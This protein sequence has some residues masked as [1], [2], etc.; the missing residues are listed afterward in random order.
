ML[1]RRGDVGKDIDTYLDPRDKNPGRFLSGGLYSRQLEAYLERFPAE[2][3]LILFFEDTI[4]R[5]GEQLGRVRSFLGLPA[6]STEP[7]SHK[8]VKDRKEPMVGPGLR[9]IMAPLKPL[10]R[11][12]RSTALF[13][14]ARSAFANEIA[15]PPLSAALRSRLVDF[16][17]SDAE[18]LGT[19]VRRD[20]SGWLTQTGGNTPLD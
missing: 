1:Y 4:A 10:V 14:A 2:R 9:K 6:A 11:P 12:F 8:R 13:A 17:A 3:V 7:V 20:L 15:Y 16:Y 18:R 5:P 19:L